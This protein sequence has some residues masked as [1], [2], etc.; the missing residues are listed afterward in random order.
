MGNVRDLINVVG[1]ARKHKDTQ[2]GLAKFQKPLG[3]RGIGKRLLTRYK[4]G[5]PAPSQI[6]PLED[7]GFKNF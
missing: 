3:N 1:G 4:G 5:E 7:E 6:I 2:S